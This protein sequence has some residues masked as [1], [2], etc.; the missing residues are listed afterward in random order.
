MW[1]LEQE[2]CQ[3]I[4]SRSVPSL[5][6]AV[7][8]PLD[9]NSNPMSAYIA[10]IVVLMIYVG[11]AVL[12]T[13][14]VIRFLKRRLK[15]RRVFVWGGLFLLSVSWCGVA[16]WDANQLVDYWAVAT[17]SAPAVGADWIAMLKILLFHFPLWLIA[18]A[19]SFPAAITVLSIPPR[20]IIYEISSVWTR[21]RQRTRSVLTGPHRMFAIG[22]V[23][24]ALA[25][26]AR[27]GVWLFIQ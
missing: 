19:P 1:Y 25:A 23:F 26:A 11:F 6:R 4:R 24:I 10:L 7:A 2:L 22:A 13:Y 17:K 16:I 9:E 14:F 20:R 15:A 3:S 8:S 27:A 18:L 5:L 21:F 12:P